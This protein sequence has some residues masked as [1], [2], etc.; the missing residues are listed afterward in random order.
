LRSLI[1]VQVLQCRTPYSN[2]MRQAKREV[3]S[4]EYSE[5]S[6]EYSEY[7]DEYSD[8]HSDQYSDEYRTPMS[9]C[10]DEYRAQ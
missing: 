1:R 6:D 5:Y 10:T 9:L 7:S 4:D 8:E 3:H 2:S